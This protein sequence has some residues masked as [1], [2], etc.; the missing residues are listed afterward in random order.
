MNALAFLSTSQLKDYSKNGFLVVK[1]FFDSQKVSLLKNAIHSIVDSF[2]ME[3]VSIFSTKSQVEKTNTY[4]LE[5]SSKISCFFEEDAFN[6]QGILDADK[7]K[8]IN[9][10]GH[11]LH[12][13][14]PTFQSVSY[15]QSLTNLTKDLGYIRPLIVQSQYIFKQPKIGGVV[16][17]HMDATFLFTDPVSCIGIWIALEDATINNGC[18]Y[19][20]PGSH[21]KY[22]LS[23]RFVR[24]ISK[25]G[26]TDFIAIS[27]T[28]ENWDLNSMVPLEVKKGDMVLLHGKCVH[29]SYENKSE[30]SRH[31]YVMHLV[32]GNLPWDRLNWLQRTQDFLFTSLF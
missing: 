15:T 31:A 16:N 14:D 25:Y 21:L 24:D 18:L 3:E 9:K 13:L 20:I 30:Q 23:K 2:N 11:A 19:A 29:M 7:H 1:N 32:E 28:I 6:T 17:P 12:D 10:V 27:Q 8:A 5:S 26:Y 4:F 22:A